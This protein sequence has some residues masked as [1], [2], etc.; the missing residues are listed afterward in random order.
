MS[1]R[2]PRYIS[3]ADIKQ[4]EDLDEDLE[5]TAIAYLE[6]CLNLEFLSVDP[7]KLDELINRMDQRLNSFEELVTHR[8]SLA[9][10]SMSRLRNKHACS[11][12]RLP[13]ELLCRIFEFAVNLYDAEESHHLSFQHRIQV[14]Y[15]NLHSL[16]GVCTA[17]RR[18]GISYCTLWS[19]VPI[20][21]NPNG[22]FM[23]TAA[24]LSL[25]R[26][27]GTKLHL[28][29]ELNG[30]RHDMQNH[31]G[32]ILARFSPRFG[33]VNL[34]ADSMPPIRVAVKKLVESVR[35]TTN[36]LSGLSLCH[37]RPDK[38]TPR[39]ID[40]IYG[41][42]EQR[43]FNRLIEPLQVLRLCGLKIYFGG[44]L[45]RNLTELRLQDMWAGRI[46]DVQDFLWSLSSSSQL[47]LLEIISIFYYPN[48]PDA[49]P[50]S[51]HFPINLPAL[52]LLYL[53]DLYK[54][55]LDLILGSIAPGSH[56]TTLHL[57]GK[58][59]RT[60]PPRDGE[61][62][63]FHDSKLRDFKI[64]TLMIGYNLGSHE[65]A[66][67]PLLELVPRVT[68]LYLDCLAL[69]PSVLRPIINPAG[70]NDKGAAIYPFFTP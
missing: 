8:L 61:V 67:R 21:C 60:Y 70:L 59:I 5:E 15:R 57:T 26:A 43:E 34:Y 45:F 19:L 4:W 6:S 13:D 54:D 42:S 9:R 41:Q 49:A 23:P 16:L 22:R 55:S 29:A 69:T 17:W 62:L 38:F 44:L 66:L 10:L 50:R 1:R 27:A 28:V 12:H 31:V 35:D 18:V 2:V 56:H 40:D 30:R 11:I 58:C 7:L 68:S 20:I 48:E 37:Q 63:G 46:T 52:E 36:C 64:D 39:G 33:T 65:A 3:P 51:Y 32:D 47:R 53:E 25:E 14:I 24:Q